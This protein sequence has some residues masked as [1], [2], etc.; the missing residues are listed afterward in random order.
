MTTQR[1]LSPFRKALDDFKMIRD[2]DK[3]AVGISG[4]K[5]SLTLLKLLAEY[6]RFSPEKFDLVAITID[7][8]FKGSENDFTPIKK[9]CDELGV[10]YVVEKTDIGE[11]IF[12]IRKESNPCSLCSKMRKNFS[13]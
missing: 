4:G 10:P 1:M 9:F 2:G 6:K 5:D 13:I 3:I 11:I 8:N 7:L 12:D